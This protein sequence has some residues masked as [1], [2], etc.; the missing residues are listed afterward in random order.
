MLKNYSAK[1]ISVSIASILITGGFADGE[2]IRIEQE[3][4]NFG[5]VVGTDGEVTRFET[6]DERATITLL[7][8]QSAD[9]NN[10]LSQLADS[11]K[12][13][14]N[15]AGV[16]ALLVR[17]RNGTAVYRASACWLRKPPNVAFGREP[18]PREWTFRCAN[19]KR[20]DGGG[21]TIGI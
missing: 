4:D 18:G 13:V 5:D 19:L 10:A 14:P 1:G 8:M 7:L 11:D 3:S 15:G 12:N 20:F 21:N 9:A 6:G 16:G 17:D 2:F